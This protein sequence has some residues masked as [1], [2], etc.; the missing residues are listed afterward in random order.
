MQ[1]ISGIVLIRHPQSQKIGKP[2]LKMSLGATK[3]KDLNK[4]VKILK[5]P[6]SE[7]DGPYL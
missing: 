7:G 3:P 5:S 4:T 1:H 2:N 6:I